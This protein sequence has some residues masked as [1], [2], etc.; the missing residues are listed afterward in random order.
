MK[1]FQVCKQHSN[2]GATVVLKHF[3][4]YSKQKAFEHMSK[5]IT[6]S[7]QTYEINLNM[8]KP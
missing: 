4:N 2:L 6:H 5:T 3:Q 7:Y 1:I 8:H